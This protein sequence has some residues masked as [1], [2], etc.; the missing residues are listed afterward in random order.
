MMVGYVW[1]GPMVVLIVIEWEK[2]ANMIY[3]LHLHLLLLLP[4]QTQKNPVSKVYYILEQILSIAKLK[5]EQ[6]ILF[7]IFQM[8]WKA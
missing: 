1:N 4:T 7:S 6:F 2:K 8:F 5:S 3:H